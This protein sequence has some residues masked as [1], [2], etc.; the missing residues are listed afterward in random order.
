LHRGLDALRDQLNPEESSHDGPSLE[1][2]EREQRLQDVIAAYLDAEKDGQAPAREEW[3]A[4]HPDLADDLRRCLDNQAWA[5]R[6]GEPLRPGDTGPTS[7]PALGVVRY[8]GDYELLAE[9]ARGAMGVVYR[10]RQ[11]SLNRTVA[12]KMILAGQLAGPAELRRFRAEAEAAANLD[13]PHIVPIYEVGEHDGQ[14]YFSMRLVEGESLAARLSASGGRLPPGEVAR[15]VA[16]VAR[17]VHH[18][19]QRGILHR[20]LKPA[21]ILLDHDDTPLV[22]DF[23]LARRVE[24]EGGQTQSGALVGTPEYMAPEQA[25]AEKQP[26]IAVDIWALGVILYECLTGVSPFRAA[27]VLDTLWKVVHEEPAPPRQLNATVPRDL[28]TICLKCQSKEPRKRFANA[29]ELAEELER[30]LR[31][32]PI[33]ARPVGRLE[34]AWRWCRRN[35]VVAGLITL[36]ALL[37]V[38]GTT[39][40]TFFAVD[41]ADK[42]QVAR[43]NAEATDAERRKPEGLAGKEARARATADAERQKAVNLAGERAEALKQVAKEKARVVEQLD[44]AE[45]VA[46]AFRLREAQAELERGRLQEAQAVLRQCDPKLCR[47]EHDYLFRQTMTLRLELKGHSSGGR[48]VAFSPDGKRIASGSG[49]RTVKDWDAHTGQEALTLK[50]HT[51]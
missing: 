5:Q 34:R 39:V 48:S 27:T 45:F 8:F 18:A 24:G 14:H 40:S 20:D 17:A 50:G 4:H 7:A 3:L 25:R 35:P 1:S 6:L 41:A 11:V 30:F 15:L 42:A 36:V 23:G 28:E 47:W 16:T 32:E 37:L 29:L 19:H 51:G 31:G 43:K 44:R 9:V 22:T 49:D 12:L 10:A 26:T 2:G 33:M 38:A 13:H 46:Y 21:N